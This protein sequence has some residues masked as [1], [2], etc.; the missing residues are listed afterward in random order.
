MILACQN[1][2][3]SFGIKEVLKDIQFHIEDHEKT[4]LVGINGAGKSTLFKIIIG[5]EA[6]DS[7]QVILGKDKTIGYLA[8]QQEHSYENTIYEEMLSVKQHIFTRNTT[9]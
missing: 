8:Q 2:T 1:I 9:L 5:E 7:G 4:A 6:P 3:K